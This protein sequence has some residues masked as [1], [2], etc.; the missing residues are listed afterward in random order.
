M[1]SSE[2]NNPAARIQWSDNFLLGFGPMDAIHQEFVS[3]IAAIQEA[4]DAQLPDLMHQLIMH[5]REHFGEEDDWMRSTQ[6]PARECHMN[7][8][9]AVMKSLHEVQALLNQGDTAVC[10]RLAVELAKWFPGHA[11]YL[12]VALAHWMCKQRMGGKPVVLRPSVGKRQNESVS[13]KEEDF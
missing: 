12:D 2:T 13:L 8:H 3:C 1:D 7:E 5:T 9:A 10:R 11:D 6:F 4:A